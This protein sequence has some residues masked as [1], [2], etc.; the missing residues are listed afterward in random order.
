MQGLYKT[1][2]LNVAFMLPLFQK[3]GYVVIASILGVLLLGIA[4]FL[5]AIL[6]PFLLACFLAYVLAPL[7][8]FLSQKKIADRTIPRGAAVLIVYLVILTVLFGGGSIMVP[9]VYNEMESMVK[10]LPQAAQLMSETW[11]PVVND[12]LTQFE[13]FFPQSKLSSVSDQTT[14]STTSEAARSASSASGTPAQWEQQ[15]YTV[16][17]LETGA[18]ELHPVKSA[19]SIPT[20]A[21]TTTPEKAA[22]PDLRS[23]FSALVQSGLKR[24]QSDLLK[25]LTLGQQVVSKVAASVF[26]TFLTFMVAAFILVDVKRI[27]NFVRSL[28][29]HQHQQ[30]YA[31][32]L[33][34]LDIGLNGVVRGQLIICVI[35]GLLT[36]V[37]LIWIGVPFA[38]TLAIVATICSLIPIFGTFISSIPIVLMALTVSLSSALLALGWILMVHFIEGNLL[39]PKI[40]GTSAEIHPALIVFALMAGEYLAGIAGALLAVPIFSILQTMFLF[41]KDEI[42]DV[43]LD[44]LTTDAENVTNQPL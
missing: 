35:N 3:N 41:L 30:Q 23:Q 42:L 25:F 4:L 29:P 27:S 15:L 36:F 21:T 1:S 7:I 16:K 28:T 19:V 34:K 17:E 11:T 37:G 44:S 40:M 38:F 10:E 6:F 13:T 9:K 43:P 5:N 22:S 32:F 31:Q 18:L 24:M 2:H 39:N 33:K 12:L 20:P 26:S 8:D 14:V